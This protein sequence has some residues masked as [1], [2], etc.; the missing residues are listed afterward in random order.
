[1][2][3]MGV[4]LFA[5]WGGGKKADG[6]PLTPADLLGREPVRLW[7]AAPLTEAQRE[8]QEWAEMEAEAKRDRTLLE[9][10]KMQVLKA[11]RE[12]QPGPE[13]VNG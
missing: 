13:I 5:A 9:I 6:E 1:M 2:A 7:P 11:A 10:Y 12:G 3:L 8:A 4:Y